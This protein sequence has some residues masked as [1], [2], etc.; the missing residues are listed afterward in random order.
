MRSV[1]STL[2][3]T[4]A[5]GAAGA[6]AAAEVVSERLSFYRQ[7]GAGEF[8]ADRG[9]AMWT[10][11]RGER[12]QAENCATCHS[13]NLKQPGKHFKTGKPIEP[14]APSVNPK[15]LTDTANIEKWFL[16][17]CKGTW[18]REC[19]DQEKGDFLLFISKQ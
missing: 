17:N 1:L 9:Q 11:V 15:R 16:R 13:N 4:A 18:G 8:S 14:L 19:T 3:F 12:G 5:L 10:E 7:N 6:V 2:V